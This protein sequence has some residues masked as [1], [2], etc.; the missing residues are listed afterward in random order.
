MS[1]NSD[2]PTPDNQP[3]SK[4]DPK[5]SQRNEIYRVFVLVSNIGLVMVFSIM[6]GFFLGIWLDKIFGKE[7]IFLIIFILVGISSGFYQC[8][9]ILKKELYL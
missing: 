5:P 2:K 8:Y 1:S 3:A 9:R 4:S 6:T 7:Y